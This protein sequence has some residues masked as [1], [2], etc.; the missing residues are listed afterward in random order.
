LE[1]GIC[2]KRKG[3]P[4]EQTV[5]AWGMVDSQPT[6]AHF[7]LRIYDDVVTRDTCDTDGMIEKTNEAYKDSQN[8]KTR[9][10]RQWIVGTIWHYAETYHWIAEQGRIK[11]RL[12]SCTEEGNWPGT[13]VFMEYSELEERYIDQGPRVFGA[14]MLMDISQLANKSLQADW[15]VYYSRLDWKGMNVYILADPAKGKDKRH[16]YT[17]IV[18][19]GL[20]ADNNIYVLDWVRDKLS[21]S[22]RFSMLQALHSKYHPIGVYYEEYGVQSDIQYF[23]EKMQTLGYHFHLQKLGGKIKKDTRI[24]RMVPD[25]SARRW[26]L[27]ASCWKTNYEGK[28]ID[29]TSEFVTKEFLAYP[30]GEHD[31]LLDVC[32]R[33]YDIQ[34]RI[35]P[36]Y[37]PDAAM[38]QFASQAA[39]ENPDRWNPLEEESSWDIWGE[40]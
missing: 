15:L 20:A 4:K 26:L 38:V 14:Q 27:P 13:P 12:F 28:R 2:V 32:S 3:R 5:E 29:V 21:L 37:R 19:L 30:Y 39:Y 40:R 34:E 31:D 24:E 11:P 18:V 35:Y 8:T 16:D 17:A 9:G 22:E 36:E 23:R 7:D 33:L 10:G 1:A 6:G 25:L